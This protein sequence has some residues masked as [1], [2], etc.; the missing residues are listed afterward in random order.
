MTSE[1]GAS[2]CVGNEGPPVAP[3]RYRPDRTHPKRA[4]GRLFLRTHKLRLILPATLSRP[5]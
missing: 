5:L 1:L 4:H 3:L 2:C